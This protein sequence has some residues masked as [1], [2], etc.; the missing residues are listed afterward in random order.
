MDQLT[1]PI[2]KVTAKKCQNCKRKNPLD[3]T[4]SQCKK[5][6]CTKCRFDTEHNCIPKEMLVDKWKQT[7]TKQLPIIV[8]NK[9]EKI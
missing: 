8:G 9:I 7:L 6:V 1:P 2:L 3:L 4:C 5:N